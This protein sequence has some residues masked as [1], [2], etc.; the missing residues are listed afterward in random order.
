MVHAFLTIAI[1]EFEINS[2][3]GLGVP[4]RPFCYFSSILGGKSV[5]CFE[6]T[7]GAGV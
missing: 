4:D 5:R 7:T 2:A 6:S 3:E 1:M